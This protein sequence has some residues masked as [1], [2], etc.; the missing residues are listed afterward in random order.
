MKYACSKNASAIEPK[1][2]RNKRKCM[3][4]LCATPVPWGLWLE[5]LHPSCFDLLIRLLLKNC[6]KELGRNK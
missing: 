1:N 5:K 4:K 6:G 3:A 2:M